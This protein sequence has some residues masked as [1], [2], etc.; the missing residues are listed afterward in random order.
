MTI[1]WNYFIIIF[2][3]SRE[4]HF[5][6]ASDPDNF[7]GKCLSSSFRISTICMNSWYMLQGLETNHQEIETRTYTYYIKRRIEIGIKNLIFFLLYYIFFVKLIFHNKWKVIYVINRLKWIVHKV[8][9][10]HIYIIYIR[11][12]PLIRLTLGGA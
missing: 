7:I 4:I 8:K 11:S 5:K 9:Y 3:F 6:L 10:M 1:I 12:T 2:Y